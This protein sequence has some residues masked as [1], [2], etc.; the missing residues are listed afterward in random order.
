MP[1][2]AKQFVLDDAARVER[3]V[4]LQV[5]RDDHAERWSRAELE[6]ELSDVPLLAIDRAVVSL[7]ENEVV[8]M[9]GKTLSASRGCRYL[10]ALGLISV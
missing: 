4:A 10:D 8:H 6:R 3:A 1:E 9:C 5:L 7:A 2:Q